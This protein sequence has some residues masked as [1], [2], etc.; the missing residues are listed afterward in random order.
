[1]GVYDKEW[2]KLCILKIQPFIFQNHLLKQ[3]SSL[4]QSTTHTL[5][6]SPATNRIPRDTVSII[7]D[8]VCLVVRGF[9]LE[10]GVAEWSVI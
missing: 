8:L 9:V 1:M 2:P 6:F 3:P 4:N 7:L 5:F 10:L